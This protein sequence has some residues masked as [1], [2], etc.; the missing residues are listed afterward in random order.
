[1]GWPKGKPRGPRK[2]IVPELVT[3]VAAKPRRRLSFMRPPPTEK[4]EPHGIGLHR[5]RRKG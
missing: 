3:V 5:I 1:M 4:Q 2:P